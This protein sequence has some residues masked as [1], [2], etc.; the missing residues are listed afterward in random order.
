MFRYIVA[1]SA[2]GFKYYGIV[3]SLKLG[4]IFTCRLFCVN[5]VPLQIVKKLKKHLTLSLTNVI[6]M[7][8]SEQK[9][10]NRHPKGKF[11]KKRIVSAVLF[12]VIALMCVFALTACFNDMDGTYDVY[13][14]ADPEGMAIEHRIGTITFSSTGNKSTVPYFIGQ[15][16]YTV[17]GNKLT[18]D[19]GGTK[20]YFEKNDKGEWVQYFLNNSNPMQRMVLRKQAADSNAD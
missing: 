15:I 6:I 20:Y 9:K 11:M 3:A 13:S 10:H 4:G 16:T 2:R 7:R 1:H 8:V 17:S 12:A 19:S 18:L 14:V 5:Y